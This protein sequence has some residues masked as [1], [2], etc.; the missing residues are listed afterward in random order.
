MRCLCLRSIH[1]IFQFLNTVQQRFLFFNPRSLVVTVLVLQFQIVA[2]CI[3]DAIEL[4]C[5]FRTKQSRCTARMS[6]NTR[7][8]THDV[9]IHRPLQPQPAIPRTRR[10]STRQVARKEEQTEQSICTHAH[11]QRYIYIHN[12]YILTLNRTVDLESRAT[13]LL[14]LDASPHL[15]LALPESLPPAPSYP[16]SAPAPSRLQVVCYLPFALATLRPTTVIERS[17]AQPHNQH[18]VEGSSHATCRVN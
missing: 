12:K 14:T 10:L 13:C 9:S 8:T 3:I 17:M 18:P 11:T 7:T 16:R 1:V 5:H 6:R 4:D 15:L 2:A